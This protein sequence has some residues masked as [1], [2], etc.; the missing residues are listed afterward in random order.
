MLLHSTWFGTF[1]LEK[2]EIVE[3]RPYPQDPEILATNMLQVE[4]GKLLRQERQIV[5]GLDEFSV[6][7]GRL[8]RLGGTHTTEPAPFLDPVDFG[9]DVGLLRE[10]MIAL[11]K[12]RL[13]RAVEPADHVIQGIRTLD[14]VTRARD[15]LTERLRDWYALHFPE[16]SRMVDIARFTDLVAERGH[17]D[18]M[19]VDAVDSVGAEIET[20]D[21]Q[22][23]QDLATSL[24][25]LQRERASL[26][27]Y[28][29]TRMRELAPNV[30][31]L[32]GPLVGARL[33]A[34]TGG[35][36]ELARKPSSTI[37]LLGAEKA[38]FRHLRKG[39]KPPKHGVLFQHPWVHD[40][41]PWQRGP[42][43]RA[44]AGKIAI[45][46]RADA[47]TGR[48]LGE[49]LRQ[50]VAAAVEEA[51]RTHTKPVPRRGGKGRPRESRRR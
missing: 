31:H 45:G 47:Y 30:A 11:G 32:A 39:S 2:G 35:L 38:L 24:R 41:P 20:K 46:A 34:L 10:A 12:R 4:E 44:L 13:R 8:E 36:E 14:D 9:F 5:E 42:I 33:I 26:E 51:K 50:E 19:P 1:L 17:R 40:A 48:F 28:V 29:E 43:A 25:A 18:K 3:S 27:A 7:E 22:A 23:V 37:Q 15:L 21:L 49:E 16:L 6:T